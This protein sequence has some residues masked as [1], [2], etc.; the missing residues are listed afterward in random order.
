VNVSSLIEKVRLLSV[1]I[2][3]ITESEVRALPEHEAIAL[4]WHLH[5]LAELADKRLGLVKT[6]FRQA[7]NGSESK[8]IDGFDGLFCQVTPQTP[9]VELRKEVDLNALRQA[10]G[11]RFIGYFEETST[12]KP[13][14]NFRELI[15]EAN[16]V[17]QGVLLGAVTLNPRTPQVRFELGS[18]GKAPE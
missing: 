17:D 11:H 8:R 3:Q 16:A 12:T 4:G 1:Q 7:V 2:D 13:R 14:R 6:R 9:T 18:S 5:E 10:L 15:T